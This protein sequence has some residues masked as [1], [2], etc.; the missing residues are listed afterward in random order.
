MMRLLLVILVLLF[1]GAGFAGCEDEQSSDAT[2]LG[3]QEGRRPSKEEKR[4]PPG[5]GQGGFQMG[6]D[7]DLPEAPPPPDDN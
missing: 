6:E 4:P 1:A 3:I 7:D 5:P 2:E